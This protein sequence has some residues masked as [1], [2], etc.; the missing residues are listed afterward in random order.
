[1]AFSIYLLERYIPKNV[2]LPPR[3]GFNLR[4]TRERDIPRN[5]FFLREKV[6]IYDAPRLPRKDN[7]FDQEL[8]SIRGSKV[9]RKGSLPVAWL[10]GMVEILVSD[11]TSSSLPCS[12]AFGENSPKVDPQFYRCPATMGNDWGSS[13]HGYTDRERVKRGIERELSAP[14]DFHIFLLYPPAS[15]GGESAT[16]PR[17]FFSS[18][19]RL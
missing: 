7:R 6:L 3:G 17:M 13:C 4:C 1:M 5:V 8:P 11:N 14:P 19:R 16:F 12:G 2:F 10:D 18:A 9:W 15:A